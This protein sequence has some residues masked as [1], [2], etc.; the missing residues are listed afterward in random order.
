MQCAVPDAV[1]GSISL[2]RF[3]L[4]CTNSIVAEASERSSEVLE[5]VE[6][7]T[8]LHE[9]ALL[10]TSAPSRARTEDPLIKS[11]LLYQLS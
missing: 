2:H 6:D 4:I 8:D 7:C 5:N 3:A 9:S 10:Y 11:Q 1:T